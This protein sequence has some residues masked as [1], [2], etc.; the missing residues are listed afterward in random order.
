MVTMRKGWHAD[1]IF[2]DGD[3]GDQ[4]QQPTPEAP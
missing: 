4:A 1:S 2:F 3:I